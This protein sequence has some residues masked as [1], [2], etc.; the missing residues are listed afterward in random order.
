MRKALN[1][2]RALKNLLLTKRKKYINIDNRPA[3]M[4]K[5]KSITAIL[6]TEQ[7]VATIVLPNHALAIM[8]NKT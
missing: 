1:R 4:F 6:G 8:K 2:V 3:S 5:P 7:K